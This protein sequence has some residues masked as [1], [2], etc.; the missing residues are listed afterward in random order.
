MTEACLESKANLPWGRKA[1]LITDV[2]SKALRKGNG[3]MPVGYS[4]QIALRREQCG[5]QTRC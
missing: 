3:S 1:R 2:T 4:R 5:M